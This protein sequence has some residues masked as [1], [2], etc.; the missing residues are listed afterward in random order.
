MI[1]ACGAAVLCGCWAFHGDPVQ[2]MVSTFILEAVSFPGSCSASLIKFHGSGYYLEICNL[3]SVWCCPRIS[4][5]GGWC[6]VH[7]AP[8]PCHTLLTRRESKETGLRM[9]SWSWRGGSVSTGCF[10]RGPGFIMAGTWQLF[11]WP[12][13]QVAGDS[14]WLPR[15]PNASEILTR[16]SKRSWR[17]KLHKHCF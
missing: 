16:T 1:C 6:G 11:T 5:A 12:I 10:S 8:T 17:I 14:V 13:T 9:H 3:A 7:K 15:A 2:G 4:E